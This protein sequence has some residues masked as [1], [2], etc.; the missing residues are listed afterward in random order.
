MPHDKATN[1][2]TADYIKPIKQLDCLLVH[3]ATQLAGVG[4]QALEE[5][6]A[7]MTNREAVSKLG[8]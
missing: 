6:T 5:G 8:Q 2:R 1:D 7:L 4:I 3:I